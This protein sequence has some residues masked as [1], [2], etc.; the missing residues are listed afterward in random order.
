MTH[1]VAHAFEDISVSEITGVE[2]FLLAR[3]F[4]RYT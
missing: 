4:E 2:G 1:R 3:A